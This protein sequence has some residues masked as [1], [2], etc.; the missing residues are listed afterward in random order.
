MARPSASVRGASISC[1]AV[2][3][4]KAASRAL[5]L[6]I[7]HGFS[8]LTK[9]PLI[10][11]SSSG[12]RSSGNGGAP[13][14]LGLV[15]REDLKDGLQRYLCLL[16]IYICLTEFPQTDMYSPHH[17]SVS[18]IISLKSSEDWNEYCVDAGR[19]RLLNRV[20][21]GQQDIRGRSPTR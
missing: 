12:G 3:L 4:F 21:N 13:P 7:S 16:G 9:C 15:L 1:R 8:F 11:R 5:S 19:G 17:G 20:K 14:L 10:M 2:F 18:S 6:W